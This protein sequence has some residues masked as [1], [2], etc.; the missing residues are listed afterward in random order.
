MNKVRIQYDRLLFLYAY[1]RQINLSL[2]RSR[3]ASWSEFQAYYKGR[4]EPAQVIEYLK[5][6]FQ[7][8]STDWENF[9]FYPEERTSVK[10]L[11]KMVWKDNFLKQNEILYGCK[12]LWE[13]DKE[14]KSDIQEYN[15]NREKLRVDVTVF[16]NEVL[17]LLISHKD[18]N[19]LMK[20]EHYE[21]NDKIEVIKMSEFVPDD[22]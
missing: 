13:F 8:P 21:Q 22:F 19:R 6:S 4:I 1:F 11:K 7:L 5:K 17:G 18:L 15:L 3:W 12:L 10:R 14:L 9:T 2:D 20:V 16:Y